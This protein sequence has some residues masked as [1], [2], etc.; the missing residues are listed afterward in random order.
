MADFVVDASVLV[1]IF[2]REPESDLFGN[3]LLDNAWAIGVPNVFEARIWILRKRP[4][5]VKEFT[6]YLD[7]ASPRFIAF[8]E[9]I[10]KIAFE[11][12]DR[13]GK[14]RHAAK[15]NF[16]DCMA[17]ATAKSLELPLLFKGGD[18]GKTDIGAHSASAIIA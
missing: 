18:F 6:N 9:A 8:D 5:V 3:I 15:L 10:E 11:G 13:F 1:A 16:G 14:G 2:N 7:A 17:Y 4:D 12:F